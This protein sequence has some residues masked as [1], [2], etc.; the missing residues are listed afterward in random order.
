MTKDQFFDNALKQSYASA[1][2]TAFA[3]AGRN[4]FGH[5][6]PQQPILGE[7]E[8]RQIQVCQTDRTGGTD[9]E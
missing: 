4:M 7:N 5:N 2:D 3:E 9:V 6:E 1:A 8:L